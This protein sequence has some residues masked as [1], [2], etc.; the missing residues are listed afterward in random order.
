MIKLQRDMLKIACSKNNTSDALNIIKANNFSLA[1]IKTSISYLLFL[2]EGT[3]Y[4]IWYDAVA[5]PSGD[6]S[7][8]IVNLLYAAP[9]ENIV[10]A[11]EEI[12]SRFQSITFYSK[13]SL[14]QKLTLPANN[15]I[16]LAFATNLI[17]S[18]QNILF[19]LAPEEVYMALSVLKN[20]GFKS[21]N[22]KEKPLRLEDPINITEDN[23]NYSD[24]ALNIIDP[25]FQYIME[26]LA[27]LTDYRLNKRDGLYQI[28]T[29]ELMMLAEKFASDRTNNEL[30]TLST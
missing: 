11:K 10:D 4:E 5:I 28:A 18:L 30:M 15:Y 25:K 26:F 14:T 20:G 23:L 21:F 9:S 6:G 16:Q 12:R 17:N 13:E 8:H 7:S 27:I 22:A 1:E 24:N 2:M 19:G 3:T 29:E